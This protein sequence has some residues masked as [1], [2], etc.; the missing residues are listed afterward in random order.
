MRAAEQPPSGPR[1]VVTGDG[2]VSVA[3]DIAQVRSGVTKRG[4][5]VQEATEAN[6]K[7]MAGILTADRIWNPSE[8]CAD[9][10]IIDPGR[11]RVADARRGAEADRLQRRQPRHCQI[12]PI[13]RLG[14]MLDRMIA[15][16]VNEVWNGEFLVSDPGKAL[17]QAREAAIPTRAEG[18]R[19][20]GVMLGRVVSIEEESGLVPGRRR[21][22][23]QPAG[24]PVPIAPGE[25]T[26]H[27]TV[28]V[29]FETAA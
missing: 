18:L 6:S 26:L 11:V 22:L 9:R 14:D 25:N 20:A 10:P 4:K 27:A 28:T 2:K 24:M 13:D 8:R 3:P 29:V 23:A 5:T 16:G 1:I 7:V 21:A 19:A 17:D 12:R 15:A